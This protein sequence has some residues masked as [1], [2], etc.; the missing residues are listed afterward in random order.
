VAFCDNNFRLRACAVGV[1]LYKA[2]VV[3]A[4]I[5]ILVSVLVIYGFDRIAI[6]ANASNFDEINGV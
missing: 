6:S 5:G 3:V 1:D 4:S 2:V